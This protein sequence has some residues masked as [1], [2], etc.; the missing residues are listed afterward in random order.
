MSATPFDRE[1]ILTIGKRIVFQPDCVV[2]SIAAE[3]RRL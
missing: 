3:I 1:F 2:E